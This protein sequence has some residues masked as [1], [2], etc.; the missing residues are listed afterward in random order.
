[1]ILIAVERK[2]ER[3]AEERKKGGG[4]DR[5]LIDRESCLFEK[6]AASLA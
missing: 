1:M 2:Q 3:L 5:A 6:L 4:R